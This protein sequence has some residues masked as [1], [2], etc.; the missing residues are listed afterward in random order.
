MVMY[1]VT[2]SESILHFVFF[3]KHFLF[4]VDGFTMFIF[5]TALSRAVT[6]L[7]LTL[8]QYYNDSYQDDMFCWHDEGHKVRLSDIYVPIK[9]VEH[10][11]TVERV[12]EKELK[13]YNEILKQVN[14]GRSN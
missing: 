3:H 10:Q 14:E 4:V 13:D 9:W 6:D 11:K 8:A 7:Q 2:Y 5:I 1:Y 12:R